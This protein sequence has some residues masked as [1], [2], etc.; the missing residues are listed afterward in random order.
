MSIKTLLFAGLM[1]SVSFSA[2]AGEPVKLPPGSDLVP[3]NQPEGNG[4][5]RESVHHGK[6]GV[7][8]L[9]YA[10]ERNSGLR[11]AAGNGGIHLAE[12][13]KSRYEGEPSMMAMEV[14]DR[15][16]RDP[17]TGRERENPIPN[18]IIDLN[19]AFGEGTARLLVPDQDYNGGKLEPGSI[20]GIVVSSVFLERPVVLPGVCTDKLPGL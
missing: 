11:A 5:G 8:A 2:S 10:V 9:I 16:A 3:V 19:A 14:D 13:E 1:V 18:A 6:C 4:A 7:A 20:G 12:L 17:S 15:Y